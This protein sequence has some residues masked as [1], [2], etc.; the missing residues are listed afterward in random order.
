M[1]IHTSHHA[2]HG[3][4]D[5]CAVNEFINRN[6]VRQGHKT[7]RVKRKNRVR[8]P[9]DKMSQIKQNP[10]KSRKSET[11]LNSIAVN[12]KGSAIAELN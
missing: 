12:T 6:K 3:C 10:I 7:D 4:P 2:G 11:G 5:A 9:T 8:R 1:K